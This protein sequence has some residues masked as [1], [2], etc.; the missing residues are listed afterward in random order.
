[1]QVLG[2]T[3]ARQP[4]FRL[5][6]REAAALAMAALARDGDSSGSIDP[7][8]NDSSSGTVD[9]ADSQQQQQQHQQQYYG[10]TPR[11]MRHGR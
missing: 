5:D 3:L 10:E 4:S 1:M 6:P 11:T 8:A 2:G 7:D 9:D